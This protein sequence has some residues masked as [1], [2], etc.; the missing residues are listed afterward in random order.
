M[1]RK[2]S[3]SRVILYINRHPPSI[4]QSLCGVVPRS[5]WYMEIDFLVGGSRYISFDEMGE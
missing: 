5:I 4:A 1:C 2:T 3:A